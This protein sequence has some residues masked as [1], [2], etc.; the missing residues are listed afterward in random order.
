MYSILKSIVKLKK[1]TTTQILGIKIRLF[2]YLFILLFSNLAQLPN[3]TDFNSEILFIHLP[4][5]KT[6]CNIILI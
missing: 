4:N 5:C 6:K 2:L 1:T 3:Q